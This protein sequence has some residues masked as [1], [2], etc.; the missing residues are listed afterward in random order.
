MKQVYKKPMARIE[1]FALSQTIANYC[2]TNNTDLGFASLNERPGCGWQI[3][4]DIFWTA[5]E[6]SGATYLL[7]QMQL[8]KASATTI[9]MAAYRYLIHKLDT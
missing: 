9:R 3:D 5:T 2:G 1:Y 7:I 8:L 4:N 6:G